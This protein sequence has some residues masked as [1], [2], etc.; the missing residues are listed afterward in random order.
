MMPVYFI[1]AGG[2]GGPFKIGYSENV[3]GRMHVMMW[4]RKWRLVARLRWISARISLAIWLL[5]W[6]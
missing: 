6:R 2:D 1:Q 3:K 4:W 5:R